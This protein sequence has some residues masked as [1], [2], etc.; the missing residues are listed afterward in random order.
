[1]RM[2]KLMKRL[3]YRQPRTGRPGSSRSGG[4]LI[5]VL[6]IMAVG[7]IL[8][9]SA[10][11]VTIATRDRFYDDAQTSQARLTL[12]STAKT[13][14]DAITVTQE[15][16]DSVVEM[17]A[18]A[19][20]V[21]WFQSA[22]GYGF[23]D[24]VGSSNSVAP[25]IGA[26]SEAAGG[27][28]KATFGRSGAYIT[29]DFVT[30]IN[31]T[32][33]GVS[34]NVRVIL[35][36]IPPVVFPT[37]FGSMFTLGGDDS[38]NTFNN[39]VIGRTTGY[40]PSQVLSNYV[41][42]N[43]DLNVGTGTIE[44]VGDV[45][46]TGMVL[47][48]AGNAY[49]GN[50][51][52][53]GDEAGIYTNLGGN[54]VITSEHI[55]FLGETAGVAGVF[56]DAAGNPT[57]LT[58]SPAGGV[59]GTKGQ[60]YVNTTMRKDTWGQYVLGEPY[61]IDSGVVFYDYTNWFS[62]PYTAGAIR[63]MSG[64][65]RYSPGNTDLAGIITATGKPNAA[66]DASTIKPVVLS[67]TTDL[68]KIA[69]IERELPTTA[70]AKALA[71]YTTVAQITA[72]ATKIT[73]LSSNQTFTGSSYYID[74]STTANVTGDLIF[75]LVN[76]DITLY[77]INSS[78]AKPFNVGP[79]A[80][81]TGS[82]QFIN[83]SANWGKIILLENGYMIAGKNNYSTWKG[84]IS[85]T[86]PA[87]KTQATVGTKPCLYIIGFGNNTLKAEQYAI[88]DAYIGLYGDN[89]RF[90]ADNGPIIYGRI[91]SEFFD[92]NNSFFY[93]NY[94]PAPNDPAG[95]SD[96]VPLATKYRVMAYVYS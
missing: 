49:K 86:H 92:S 90:W 53:W 60:Y 55:L 54:G 74:A 79:V 66:Y 20:E 5:L 65:V 30:G 22:A 80:S 41:V 85:T 16:R 42:L 19:G 47:S 68:D 12:T 18:D 31:A 84:I 72:N 32:G 52:F 63:N 69:N 40:D 43:G 36:I 25:G 23:T 37:G 13:V 15:L 28:T 82:L 27:W 89:G 77:I 95:G 10:L 46:Y 2:M 87:V 7:L 29:I 34:E 93:L 58:S 61:Y 26:K 83:G 67:Y 48:G 73:N 24:S 11:S 35:E 50:I 59:R 57:T 91:E 1:M 96:A 8:I 81:A 44:L 70:E 17:W 3:S 75:D 14:V 76:N 4:M 88:V 94:C 51:I 38:A 33:D 71:Q 9:T 6:V 78:S 45:V 64:D 39:T 21:V 56:L 62:D